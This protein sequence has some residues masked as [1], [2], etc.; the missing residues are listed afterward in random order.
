MKNQ[1]K[2]EKEGETE[3][4]PTERYTIFHALFEVLKEK[5]KKH[6]KKN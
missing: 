6:K 3:N 4:F 5:D 1:R 2:H